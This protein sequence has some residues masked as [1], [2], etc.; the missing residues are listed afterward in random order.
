MQLHSQ[1]QSQTFKPDSLPLS[2]ST[3]F[4]MNMYASFGA[5]YQLDSALYFSIRLNEAIIK[6]YGPVC[7]KAAVSYAGV[8]GIYILKKNYPGAS[9]NLKKA[10]DIFLQISHIREINYETFS[11]A[12]FELGMT[13]VLLGS[14]AEGE[15]WLLKAAAIN[16]Q[17][18]N[19][20]VENYIQ[21]LVNLGIIYA[22]KGEYSKSDSFY[23]KALTKLDS[24]PVSG[25][26]H[27][28]RA[29]AFNGIGNNSAQTSNFEK[30]RIDLLKAEQE[31]RFNG[32]TDNTLFE[33][34]L[35]LANLYTVTGLTDSALQ[36]CREVESNA[37]V[38]MN[39]FLWAH[40]L[41]E[42]AFIYQQ[43]KNRPQAIDNYLK[44]LHIIKTLPFRDNEFTATLVNLGILYMNTKQYSKADSIF[45]ENIQKIRQSGIRYSFV[46]QQSTAGLCASLINQQKYAEASDSLVKLIHTA[47][48]SIEINWSNLSETEKFNFRKLLDEY[49][50]LLYT[51]MYKN[52]LLAKSKIAVVSKLELLRRNLVVSNQAALLSHARHTSDSAFLTIYHNWFSNRQLLSKQY[53]LAYSQRLLNTDSMEGI[54]RHLEKKLNQTGFTTSFDKMITGLDSLSVT[55]AGTCGIEFIRV[56]YK[57]ADN[58]DHAVYAAIIFSAANANPDFVQLCNETDLLAIFKDRKGRLINENQ[59]TQKIYGS[60]GSNAILLYKLLWKPLEPFLKGIKTIRYSTAGLLNNIAFDAIFSGQHYLLNSYNL[61]RNASLLHSNLRENASIPKTINIWGNMNY[62]KADYG[63]ENGTVLQAVK[64]SA[65]GAGHGYPPDGIKGVSIEPFTAFSS[66]E[67]PVLR[68]TFDKHR[69]QLAS[70]ENELATEENFKKMTPLM[71]GILHIST[72]GFYAAYNKKNTGSRLPGNFISANANPLLRCGLAFSGA[73]YY[74]KKGVP[75]PAHEDGILTGYEISQMDLHKLNLV[76]LSA[77]ETALGD[78]TDNEGNAGLQRAFKL[79]GAENLLVS[80]WQVPVKQTNGLISSFYGYWLAGNK[81]QA[82]FRKAQ[83]QMQKKYSPYFWAGF[84]LIK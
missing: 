72:H 36:K 38:H 2:D 45:R 82:A 59:V 14:V 9:D 22:D 13:G 4:F 83:L 62:D 8:G 42:K 69:V 56:N 48:E 53:S 61:E 37:A 39:I 34:Q 25:F 80:L 23:L 66:R 18:R 24:I 31:A 35:N 33:I 6:E 5:K 30:A 57:A 76:T 58:T 77:C 32:I 73:N 71:Q 78:V 12:V 10:V 21:T 11:T 50:D 3:T 68:K 84:V 26:Y 41:K 7:E 49:F 20:Q 64:S 79:A 65:P 51:C 44:Y 52:D 17:N 27:Y 55:S 40:L 19:D 1:A 74:W 81:M 46:L 29:S 67:I 63:E 75:L 54:N 16:R 28:M 60:S 70:Y 15:K 43:Q 47:F